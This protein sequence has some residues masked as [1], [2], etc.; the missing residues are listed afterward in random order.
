[1]F[2]LKAD[3]H[4]PNSILRA[5]SLVLHEGDPVHVQSEH[6]LQALHHG[7]RV[8]VQSHGQLMLD[9]IEEAFQIVGI[10]LVPAEAGELGDDPARLSGKFEA[11]IRIGVNGMLWKNVSS[12]N[13]CIIFWF[14]VFCLFVCLVFCFVFIVCLLR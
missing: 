10:H 1:M 8:A 13:F 4:K 2:R 5:D 11:E 14:F 9:P 3:R 12:F 6:L 7:L